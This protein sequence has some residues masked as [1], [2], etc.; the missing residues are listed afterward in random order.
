MGDYLK[1]SEFN[2]SAKKNPENLEKNNQPVQPVQTIQT[3]QSLNE[4][5]INTIAQTVINAI[6]KDINSQ[7]SI[8]NTEKSNEKD[9]DISN[10][11]SKLADA[12]VVQRD[13]NESNFNNLGNIN[14]NKKDSDSTID[15]LSQLDD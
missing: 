13:A 6:K 4:D 2:I 12:M 11:L 5:A 10:S 9:F 7:G 3:V 14:N 1:K 8:Q 15:L